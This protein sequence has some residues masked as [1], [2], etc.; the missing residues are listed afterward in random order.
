MTPEQKSLAK[1]ILSDSKRVRE[2]ARSQ[3]KSKD[4]PAEPTSLIYRTASSDARRMA[5]HILSGLVEGRDNIEYGGNLPRAIV[6]LGT[7]S[8]LMHVAMDFDAQ[9]RAEEDKAYAK[10]K[11]RAAKA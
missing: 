10:A 5:K 7:A 2:I 11:K 1:K 4:V 3:I 8:D 6:S 9:A